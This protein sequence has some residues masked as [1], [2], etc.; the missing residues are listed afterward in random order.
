MHKIHGKKYRL[1]V[2]QG[3][4][5]QRDEGVRLSE[6]A[7]KPASTG[8]GTGGGK[9][10]GKG[11]GDDTGERVKPG[12]KTPAG[13]RRAKKEKRTAKEETAAQKE[14]D[15]NLAAAVKADGKIGVTYDCL[16]VYFGPDAGDVDIPLVGQFVIDAWTRLEE[17]KHYAQ[18]T[19][20]AK[21]S[22]TCCT[23]SFLTKGGHCPPQRRGRGKQN[24][25][26]IV[27]KRQSP[28][29]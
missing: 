22:S 11:G 9:A 3:Q 16:K 14:A 28:E 23:L 6:V 15:A 8:G 13:R 24:G 27:P 10:D 25:E 20:D 18:D 29:C 17:L 5:G 26:A 12:K 7:M 4:A 1:D 21:G 19:I 2:D